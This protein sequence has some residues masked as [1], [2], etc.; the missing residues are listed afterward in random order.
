MGASVITD[1]VTVKFNDAYYDN[2]SVFVNNAGTP[3]ASISGFFKQKAQMPRDAVVELNLQRLEG[4][5]YKTIGNP[6]VSSL[7]DYIE[8]NKIF[9]AG[10][11]KASNF[12]RRCPVAMK[13]YYIKEYRVPLKDLPPVLP[14][15][16]WKVTSLLTSKNI[17][18]IITNWYGRLKNGN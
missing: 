17:T 5:E 6:I 13:E 16:N 18:I 3:H 11:L 12:P 2:V 9:Y 15:G 8:Q 10:F 4:T 14:S 1:Q 7:C